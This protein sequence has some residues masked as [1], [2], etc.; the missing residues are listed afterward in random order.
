[1]KS[2]SINHN[3]EVPISELE[4]T[5]VRSSGPG[6]QNVNR[7]NSCVVLRWNYLKS[8]LFLNHLLNHEVVE[9]L[10]AMCTKDGD[11]IIK[12][13]TFR[14]QDRNYQECIDKFISVLKQA[15][16]KPKKRVPT[17]PTFSSKMRRLKSKSQHSEKKATRK[18]QIFRD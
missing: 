18:K 4:F 15:F 12:S 8:Q 6:G 13:Q 14:D 1:M 3:K 16:F 10:Q 11:L 9:K 5:Y 2:L 7:T 17:K